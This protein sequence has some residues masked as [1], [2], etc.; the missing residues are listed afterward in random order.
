VCP[1]ALLLLGAEAAVDE[2][3]H[4]GSEVGHHDAAPR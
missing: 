4:A 3:A 2:C 1:A